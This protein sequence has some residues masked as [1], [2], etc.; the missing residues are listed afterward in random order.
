[1]PINTILFLVQS[2]FSQ[3]D[4]ERFGLDILH[5]NGFRVA[6]WDLTPCLRPQAFKNTVVPDP[7]DFNGL[8]LQ[9]SKAD[10]IAALRSLDR[11]TFI[12]AM[13]PLELQTLAIFREASRRH[14][15]YGLKTGR[16]VPDAKGVKIRSRLKDRLRTMC[17][18]TLANR[19]LHEI[20]LKWLRIEPA[21]ILMYSGSEQP[22]QLTSK[23]QTP[24]NGRYV[25]IPSLDHDLFLKLD[26]EQTRLANEEPGICVFLDEYLP[27]HPDRH[28]LGIPPLTHPDDYFPVLCKLFAMIERDLGLEVVIA[29]HPRSN[30]ENGPD[31]FDGR[32][33][34]RGKTAEL[35]RK[36]QFVITHASTSLAFAVLF[37]I[38]ALFVTTDPLKKTINGAWIENFA[39]AMG[40][41]PYNLSRPYRIDWDQ[42][43]VVDQAKY[44]HYEQRF[45]R[46]A[47]VPAKPSWQIIA[48]A[49]KQETGRR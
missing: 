46:A 43:L 33:I 25:Q 10:V 38:P 48:D 35:V 21:W 44:N 20:P 7:V 24:N 29:A 40:K 28:H 31:Y 13:I 4:Y 2:P 15:R 16:T 39:N 26:G 45:I 6:V 47:G 23:G 1:M 17:F 18:E 5:E 12:I 49:L 41:K 14:I 42:E 30:Y 11:D 37:A 27:F 34:E 22:D 8:R 3:R 36:G 19:L 32:R 9:K